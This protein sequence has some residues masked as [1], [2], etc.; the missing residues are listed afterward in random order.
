MH[1]L[2]VLNYI[3]TLFIQNPPPHIYT[4][5]ALVL[6]CLFLCVKEILTIFGPVSQLCGF[7]WSMQAPGHDNCKHL[8]SL[9]VN[10]LEKQSRFS[11]SLRTETHTYTLLH[12]EKSIS[13]PHRNTD[14]FSH[15]WWDVTL[16]ESF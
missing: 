16:N 11:H 15:H 12:T 3:Q 2:C 4:C 1:D 7:S 9:V 14:I 13:T 6:Q 5:C 10:S 8:C